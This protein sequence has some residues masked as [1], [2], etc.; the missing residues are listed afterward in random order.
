MVQRL[1]VY[2]SGLSLGAVHNWSPFFLVLIGL[3]LSWQVAKNLGYAPQSRLRIGLM[4]LLWPFGF[5]FFTGFPYALVFL[6]SSLYLLILYSSMSTL[7]R[8]ACLAPVATLLASSYPTAGLYAVIPC[9]HFLS[10]KSYGS[11]SRRLVYCVASGLPFVIGTAGFFIY[12]GELFGDYSL[13]FNGQATYGRKSSNPFEFLR[14]VVKSGHFWS[15]MDIR[16]PRVSVN[17]YSIMVVL[18][19][20]LL[21]PILGNFIPRKVKRPEFIIFPFLILM[22]SLS[23]G[24]LMSIFRH[25]L[26]AYP[27]LYALESDKP[28]QYAGWLRFGLSWL[29]LV[30]AAF[31]FFQA[32]EETLLHYIDGKLM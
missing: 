3:L 17:E 22:T 23:S 13:Y 14:R 16:N 6:L 15:F 30:A 19:Y 7:W 12:L 25:L 31:F 1:I 20:M 26:L 21:S 5:Y 8:L 32:Y 24:S 29:A 18:F 9:V 10:S 27:V 2:A 28:Q 4:F 11:L